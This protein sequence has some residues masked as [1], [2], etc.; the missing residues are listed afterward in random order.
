[1]TASKGAPPLV[2]QP[3]SSNLNP[4]GRSSHK[5]SEGL[6]VLGRLIA[7][8]ALGVVPLAAPAYAAATPEAARPFAMFGNGPIDAF[9]ASRNGA[10]L[11]L[12]AGPN[13]AAALDLI[14]ILKRSG[15]EGYAE[16]PGIADRAQALLARGNSDPSA[17]READRL[18]STG[19]VGY[20]SML[21]SRPPEMT[22]AEQ[23][24]APRTETPGEILQLAAASP[25]L[26]T[27]VRS[28]AQVNP[29][30]ASLRDAAWTQVA[31]TGQSPDSRLLASLDRARVFPTTGRYVVVDAASARLWMV[32]NGRFVDSMKVIV[33]KPDSQTPIIASVI[34]YATLNP[35]WNVPPD[36]VRSMIAKNVLDQGPGYLKAH[37][38]QLL[39]DFS[40]NARI[41]APGEVDWRAVAD[42]RASVR[43]RQLPGAGNS[44]GH[45]KFGF[46]NDQGVYLHDTPRKELFASDDRDLSHG[47]IRLED[48][49]RLGR[50]LLGR[51][52]V[53]AS[54]EPEQHVLLPKPVPVYVTY[55]TAHAEDGQ[56]TLLDDN[57]RR[58][59][60]MSSTMAG[61]R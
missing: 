33:G 19:W 22:F 12:A 20:V 8:T 47:C 17:L 7:A 28:T 14:Q 16:G 32:D 46:A 5:F 23:W 40:E 34:H 39:S 11:W 48:A 36:M 24:I 44:M 29:I 43:V 25:S 52:P 4:A 9:Y 57:Y 42:G 59:G 3:W 35:Y 53:A 54:S 21:R 6:N 50:W 10:P 31:A 2:N 49:E 30:Y 26:E 27:Y 15:I 60:R 41:L 13:S 56:L 37:G 61:L 55:L 18:L 45:L 51:D 1:M 38:Y 58:D